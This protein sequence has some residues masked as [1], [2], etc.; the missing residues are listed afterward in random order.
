MAGN[1]KLLGGTMST[2]LTYVGTATVIIE[3][4]GIRFITDPVLDAAP[5]TYY[6]GPIELNATV[7]PALTRDELP[8]IDAV[9]LTHDEHVDHLD[10]SGREFA[11]TRTTFTTVSGA[12]RLGGLARGLAPW[13][14]V[15]F[16][17][18]GHTVR[19]TATPAD[20][21]AAGADVVGFVLESDAEPKALYISGDTLLTPELAEIGRR[22][23]IGVAVLHLGAA[24]LAELGEVT[25]SMSGN[26]AA[27]LANELD[28]ELVVP[29]HFEGW[30]HYKEA[31]DDITQAFVAANAD[32]RLRWLARGERTLV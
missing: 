15:D 9:L 14:S 13:E 29:V 28:A 6:L 7:S 30:G 18:D 22:F 24:Q 26:D 2:S 4:G 25:I 8:Q 27:Q 17:V 1:G 11:S 32:Q 5:S 21:G 12:G 16:T 3:F 10:A 19:I 20:H 31:T 23:P